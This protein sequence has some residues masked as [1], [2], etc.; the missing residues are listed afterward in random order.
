MKK[1]LKCTGPPAGLRVLRAALARV[2]P[3][4]RLSLSEWADERR[5]LS[6]ETAAEPG[7]FRTGRVPYMREPMDCFTDPRVTRIVAMF[8]SQTVKTEGLVWNPVGYVLDC[9]PGPILI[10]DP[11]EADAKKNSKKRLTPMLRDCPT[12]RGKVRESTRDSSNTILE[13]VGPG[14]SIIMAG[15][16]APAGLANDPIR[17]LFLNEVSRFPVSAGAEGDPVEIAEKRTTTFSN[18]RIVANSSPTDEGTCRISAMYEESDQRVYFVPCPACEHPQV[19]RWARVQWKRDDEGH[20]I[21]ETALYYCE[22]CD[23]PWDDGERIEAIAEADRRALAGAKDVGWVAQRPFNGTAGF[24]APAFLAPWTNVMLAEL[25]KEWDR[26][27]GRPLLLKT[28][29]NTRLAET[30]KE[31]YHGIVI[32]DVSGRTEEYPT[33]PDG[34]V[35]APL[36]VAV[37]TAGVDVQDDRLE[38]QIV[39]FG[40]DFEQ[41]KLQYHVLGGDP[42]GTGVWDDLW[43]L[44]TKPIPMERGGEDYVRGS[45]IDTGG[46]HTL[47]AYEF[48]RPRQRVT[49]PDGVLGYVFGIK[50]NDGAGDPWPRMASR[51]NKGKIDLYSIKV[52]PLKESLYASLAKVHEAG[53]GFIHFPRDV[54]QQEASARDFDADF[55]K[56][57][58][59]ERQH[60]TYD[61]RGRTKRVWELKTPGA[62]NEA[63]D[64][65]NYAE[66]AMHGL[67]RMGIDL[68]READAA[69]KIAG[70]KSTRVHVQSDDD[71][72][73]KKKS[74]RRGRSAESSYM[75]RRH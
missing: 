16:N 11:R 6:R 43:R 68:D 47:K 54:K 31:K 26:A 14:F 32:N 48:V 35:Q 24:H 69:L 10:V 12:L 52:D 57:L 51:N 45:A 39:G 38:V 64:T 7:R 42:S 27:Q 73:R 28:F 19:L 1:K 15:A 71:A 65:H 9:D 70:K 56:Q 40:K 36:G 53:P 72:P 21:P 13:K 22:K 44:L 5:Y 55:F 30:W 33:T 41:W 61:A 8:A 3:P 29:V 62:R 25:V 58:T 59:S 37:I 74:R 66:A 49:M 63:L 34:R 23:A 75:R 60:E 18:R 17:Y 67:V 2:K 4:P 50:G 20:S 46:H